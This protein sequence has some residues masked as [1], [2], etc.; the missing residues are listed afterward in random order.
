MLL[1][2]FQIPDRQTDR[3]IYTLMQTE[4]GPHKK[5]LLDAGVQA[6]CLHWCLFGSLYLRQETRGAGA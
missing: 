1:S 4:I 2:A 6:S 5:G 3:H